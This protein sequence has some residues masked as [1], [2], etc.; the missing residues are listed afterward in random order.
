MCYAEH[1]IDG[2]SGLNLAITSAQCCA[3]ETKALTFAPSTTFF[4]VPTLDQL[5]AALY[6]QWVGLKSRRSATRHLAVSI[7]SRNLCFWLTH[8]RLSPNI[9]SLA[10]STLGML[11]KSCPSRW[12]GFK[13]SL[14]SSKHMSSRAASTPVAVLD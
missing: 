1:R 2:E 12:N 4:V 5:A 8:R 13:S 3:S 7:S 14:L 9:P 10:G 11:K 6:L